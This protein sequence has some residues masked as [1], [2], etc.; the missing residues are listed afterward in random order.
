MYL[1]TSAFS[2][3]SRSLVGSSRMRIGGSWMSACAEADALAVAVR[4]VSDVLAEDLRQAAD[5]DDLLRALLERGRVE[6]AHV[7]DEA[8]VLPHVHVRVERRA[9]RQVAE[10]PAAPRGARRT[11]RGRAPSPCPPVGDDEAGQDAHRRRLAGAV[12]PEKADHLAAADLEAHL[13]ER[14]ERP[15]SLGQL[16]RVDHH[17]GSHPTSGS[18]KK[19]LGLRSAHPSDGTSSVNGI[20]RVGQ[21]TLT[22]RNHQ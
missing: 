15:E 20:A 4:E 7:G 8:Q 9:L 19:K 18:S 16:V 2:F 22:A 5:L 14:A 3:G 1:M 12:R 6:P 10:A 21:T 17:V 11:R 13:V